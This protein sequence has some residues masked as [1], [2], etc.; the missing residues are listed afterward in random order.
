MKDFLTEL[1][2]ELES[3]ELVENKGPCWPGYKQVGT[4]MKNGKQVP[5]CVPIDE[6][7]MTAISSWKK[8]L[9]KMKGLTKQQMQILSTLPTPVITNLINTVGMV[10]SDNDPG[11]K[12][13]YRDVIK[14]F[15]RDREWKQI[16]TKHRR[17]IDAFRNNNKDL[18]KNVED[19]LISWA[20]DNGEISNKGE[21][22]DFIDDILNEE[23]DAQRKAKFASG[24]AGG[25]NSSSRKKKMKDC[26]DEGSPLVSNSLEIVDSILDKIRDDIAKL[27]IRSQAE[28]A[29]PKIQMIAKIAGYKVTK[30]G[31]QRGKIFRYDIK[32]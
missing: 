26:M 2:K 8:K 18:P 23:T 30:K 4:K 14:M 7:D 28:R 13:N 22:E 32:K 15:P 25:P 27:I 6:A 1:R 31:Q 5:N 12:E 21:I 20:L 3:P 17:A 10:V 24:A 9:K 11:I 19:D 16:I 29:W